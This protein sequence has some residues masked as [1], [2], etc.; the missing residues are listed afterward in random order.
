MERMWEDEQKPISLKNER[1]MISG[2]TINIRAHEQ[3]LDSQLTL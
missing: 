2:I 3:R 1:R